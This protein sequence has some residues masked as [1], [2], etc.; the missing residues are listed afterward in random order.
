MIGSKYK[1]ESNEGDDDL[2]HGADDEGS[3]TLLTQLA[4]VCPQAHPDISPTIQKL[5]SSGCAAVGCTR[6]ASS[7]RQPVNL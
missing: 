6:N 3:C 2:A 4:K 7:V 5:W 1:S